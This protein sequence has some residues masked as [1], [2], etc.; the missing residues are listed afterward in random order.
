M[1]SWFLGGREFHKEAGAGLKKEHAH[2]TVRSKD[3]PQ[4]EDTALLILK[5]EVEQWGRRVQNGSPDHVRR[6]RAR[7]GRVLIKALSPS[8]G[9]LLKKVSSSF[10]G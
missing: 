7:T 9:P 3:T 5:V 8:S 2:H 10:K 1:G 4:K 6:V